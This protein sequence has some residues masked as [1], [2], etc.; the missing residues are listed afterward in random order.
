[1]GVDFGLKRVGVALSDPGR[2]VA[3]PRTVLEYDG[4]LGKAVRAVASLAREFL[5]TTVVVGMPLE[6]KGT[7]GP[8]ADRTATF[9]AQL[10]KALEGEIEVEEWDERLTSAQ[11]QRVLQ[12]AG[13]SA[14][15]M[16][17]RLDPVAA[18]LILQAYLDFS[19]R[20]KSE[21]VGQ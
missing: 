18:A 21:E 12:Q 2:S 15:E 17:G 1:M 9:I 14:R 16:K 5:A 6:M 11:A 7:R 19:S 10:R 8:Q 3:F 13:L 20:H 4:K